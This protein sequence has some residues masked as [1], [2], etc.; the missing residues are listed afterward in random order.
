M[1]YCNANAGKATRREL[2]YEYTFKKIK[3]QTRDTGVRPVAA[4]RRL[5]ENGCLFN[6]LPLAGRC[7]AMRA[8]A[9]RCG[10]AC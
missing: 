2:D 6:I 1:K 5:L 3:S 10:A 9:G 8:D 4:A 7:G